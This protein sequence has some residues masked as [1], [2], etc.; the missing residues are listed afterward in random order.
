MISICLPVIHGKYIKETLNSIYNSKFDDFEVIVNDSSTNFFIS[1]LLS[2]YD[3]RIIKKQTKSFESRYITVMAA[4]G[5]K[6]LLFDETRIMKATLLEK[7]ST[8]QNSMVAIGERELGKGII[9]FI[10]NLDK[11]SLQ[12]NAQFLSPLSNKSIIPRFYDQSVINKALQNVSK[13]LPVELFKQVVGLDLELIY[14][15]S[16]NISKDIR[17][18]PTQ[19]ILHYGDENLRAVF[20]KYYRYGHTQRMLRNTYYNDFANLSGRSRSTSPLRNR[21]LSLPLQVVR[22]VPFLLGYISGGNEKL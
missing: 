8:M 10:S 22:G 7:L 18:I 13:N 9:T 5:S 11:E 2:D 17:I 15:E 16:Y 4:K 6:I 1:D 14:L 3:V 19:E 12:D 21:L 20:H